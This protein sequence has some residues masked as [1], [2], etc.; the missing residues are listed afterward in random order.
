MKRGIQGKYVPCTISGEG[1]EGFYTGGIA[2]F[3]DLSIGR[4]S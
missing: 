1:T 3:A 4:R 2:S